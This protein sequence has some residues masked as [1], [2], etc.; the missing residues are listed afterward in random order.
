[1]RVYI[2]LCYSYAKY[3]EA[4]TNAHLQQAQMGGIPGTYHRVKGF[5][6]IKM[7]MPMQGLEV[8]ARYLFHEIIIDLLFVIILALVMEHMSQFQKP[9]TTF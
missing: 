9:G 1:M 4:T 2:T 7:P 6:N 3:I 5:L 8:W